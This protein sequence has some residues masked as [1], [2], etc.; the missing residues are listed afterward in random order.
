MLPDIVGSLKT[1]AK[2]HSFKGMPTTAPFNIDNLELLK[3]NNMTR[4]SFRISLKS[5]KQE[6]G[7]DINWW[8]LMSRQEMEDSRIR[9]AAGRMFLRIKETD[10]VLSILFSL[11][12]NKTQ[13]G[14]FH[15]IL[16][17]PSEAEDLALS[18]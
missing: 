13:N 4:V 14:H 12:Q 1:F 17:I 2:P 6:M 7:I 3:Q 15:I 9:N 11:T 18:Y 5:S 16:I 8:L 10:L